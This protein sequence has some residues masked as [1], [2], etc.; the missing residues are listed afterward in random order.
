MTLIEAIKTKRPL[1][2][3]N[4][5]IYGADGIT[6]FRGFMSHDYFLSTVRLK[7]DDI[8]ADDWEVLPCHHE[9]ISFSADIFDIP[10][11]TEL[12]AIGPYGLIKINTI[13]APSCKHCGVRIRAKGWT[14]DEQG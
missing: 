1:C 4:K 13:E 6:A 14:A 5:T 12:Q 10:G 8:I 2:R 9:P 3:S 11:R 7:A